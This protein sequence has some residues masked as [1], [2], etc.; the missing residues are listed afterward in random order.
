MTVKEAGGSSAALTTTVELS[1]NLVMVRPWPPGLEKGLHFM[2]REFGPQNR[3]K[4]TREDL[5]WIHEVD[6][7]QVG[8]VPEGF[9]ERVCRKLEKKGHTFSVKDHRR[10]RS[11]PPVDVSRIDAAGLRDG[12]DKALVEVASNYNGIIVAPTGYGK[13]YLIGQICRMYPSLH[14]VV[15]TPRKSV[16]QSLYD[17]LSSDPFLKGRVGVVCSWKNTGTAFQVVVTTT[18]SLGRM[19]C[20]KC[21][22]LLFD[23]CQGVG[24]S[25]ASTQV[26]RFVYARKFGFSASPTGRSDGADKVLEALFGPVRLDYTYQMAVDKNSVVPI[27]VRMVTVEG[28]S[29]PYESKVAVKRWGLWRN[30]TRNKAIAESVK[31]FQDDQVLIMVETID[32]AMHLKKLLPEYALIYSNCPKDRYMEYISQGFTTEPY[33]TDK[34]MMARQSEFETGQLRKAISTMRWREGVDFPK[35]RALVRAD[36]QAGPIPSTQIPG[37]LSRLD[38]DKSKGVLIDFLDKFDR[39][40]ESNSYARMGHYRKLG[41]RIDL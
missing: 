3:M 25:C 31:E 8:Y 19:D 29:V 41:W 12:Q 21:D 38:P 10:W 23:E 6:G 11:P 2:R 5:Y 1:N 37:R 15:C 9:L 35:L 4:E 40:L 18:K 7:N 22:L 17:R 16:V 14:I 20:E 24:A 36:G 13:S 32:H 30:K 28:P 27:E 33:V 39:R 34:Q 26:S